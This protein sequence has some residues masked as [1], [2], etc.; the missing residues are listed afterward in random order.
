MKVL[1]FQVAISDEPTDIALPRGSFFCHA[2]DQQGRLFTWW[3][4][5]DF[6]LIDSHRI[7]VVGTGHEVPRT[8]GYRFLA[9]VQMQNGLVWH[10]FTVCVPQAEGKK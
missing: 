1:K 4:H 10:L 6:P 3:V 9:T 2:G 7:R 8:A 5:N